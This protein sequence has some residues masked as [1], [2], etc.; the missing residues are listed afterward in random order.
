MKKDV[1]TP[2]NILLPE[3]ID[4]EN[5]SVI[6]CDQFSSEREYWDRVRERVKNSPSTFNMIIPEA[7]LDETDY[8]PI[9]AAMA[10]YSDLGLFK[11]IKDSFI[12]VERTQADGRIRRGLVG[13]VDLEEYDFSGE[14]DAA[15]LASEGTVLDRLPVRI[16]VRRQ[17]L[18]ELPHIMAFI[19]D[20]NLSVIEPLA[21]KN[22]PVL[23]DFKLMEGGGSIKGMRVDGDS[24]AGVISALAALREKSGPLMVMGDG[25][26]SLAAAKVYWDEL[27]QNLTDAEREAHPARRALL[28]VNNV[29]DPA[30][31][32]EAIHRVMFGVAPEEF[33]RTFEKV[34]QRGDDYTLRWI[35]GGETHVTGVAAACIGDM[36]TAMQTFIDDYAKTSGCV[37]DYIHGEESV[38]DLAKADGTLGLILPAMDKSE[39]FKTVAESGV[40]P[41]K[42]FS[43]GH[44]RDKRYYLEC[45]SIRP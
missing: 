14:G 39:L 33:I 9:H 10:E 1:F 29:Y 41:K 3:G 19:D 13:A 12:Y 40:F 26:H 18:L 21:K 30:I 5:W 15:I 38:E 45:R 7:Y 42:S 23:Y 20:K 8:A 34:T 36:L 32:F 11:E 24:A 44:A 16:N 17:A 43:V 22:L 31:D 35:Y 2:T 25:N 27:K 28:E 37:V 4:M 6:A